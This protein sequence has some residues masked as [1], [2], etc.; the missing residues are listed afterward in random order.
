[1]KFLGGREQWHEMS[2]LGEKTI[3]IKFHEATI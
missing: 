3:K 2:K 1:M